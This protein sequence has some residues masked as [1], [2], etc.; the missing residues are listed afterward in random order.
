MMGGVD[1][2]VQA[3]LPVVVQPEEVMRKR[4]LGAAIELC[5]E[6]AGL[7]LDKQSAA[8]MGVD[9][10]QFSRW[11][12]G[13]EGIKWERL[14]ALMSACGNE[15]PVLWMAH[16]TGFDIAAMHKV[17]SVQERENQL[18]REENAALRRALTRGV[19]S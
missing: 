13:A 6:L 3:G 16:Q 17:R 7:S 19:V 2:G 5:A 11:I 9:K 4:S 14:A 1:A 8:V 15:A 10:G 18:L 12:S